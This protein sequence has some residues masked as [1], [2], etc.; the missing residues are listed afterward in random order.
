MVI[1]SYV[2]LV[3]FVLMPSAPPWYQGVATNLVTAA[4]SVST[5]GIYSSSSILASYIHFTSLIEAD[6]YA[7]FPSLHA[8]YVVLFCYFMM[9]Y[10]SILGW[11]TIPLVFGVLFSTLYLGQHYLIDLIAGTSLALTSAVVAEYLVARSN[12][13]TPQQKVQIPSSL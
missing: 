4:S 12:R 6:K 13:P 3:V 1:T 8:A 2:A 7:A 9:R 10:R 11:I 5:T